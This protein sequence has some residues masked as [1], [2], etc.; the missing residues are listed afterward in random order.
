MA[1][2]DAHVNFIPSTFMIVNENYPL[3][4]VY[5][6][7]AKLEVLMRLDLAKLNGKLL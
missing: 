7:R 3:S 2:Q 4:L 6:P 1:D 5:D